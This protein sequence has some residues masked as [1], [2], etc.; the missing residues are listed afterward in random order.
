MVYSAWQYIFTSARFVCYEA[1]SPPKKICMCKYFKEIVF[2]LTLYTI[3]GALD[4][5]FKS[6]LSYKL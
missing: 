5:Y 2:T 4:H 1:P 3:K 6:I